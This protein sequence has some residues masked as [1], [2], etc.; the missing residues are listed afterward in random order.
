MSRDRLQMSFPTGLGENLAGDGLSCLIPQ[1]S[2]VEWLECSW[3]GMRCGEGGLVGG[4]IVIPPSQQGK[5]K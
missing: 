1:E 4:Y 2:G 5:R 3:N